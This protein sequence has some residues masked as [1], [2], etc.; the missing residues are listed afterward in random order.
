MILLVHASP[1]TLEPYRTPHL[2]V[3]CSPRRVY[4]DEL[5]GWTWAADNDAFSAW[6]EL[7]YYEMLERIEG[8]SGC[9]FVTAPDR[10]GDAY[11][12]LQLFNEWFPRL[13]GR[14]PIGYV[15]QDGQENEPVP[16]EAI[17]AVFVGGTDTFKMGP[18]AAQLVREAKDR[19]LWVHMGRVNGH[20]RLRYAKALGC[21]SVD[22]T[23]LSWFRDRWLPEYLAHAA[24]PAQGMLA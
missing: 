13:E 16:W 17:D 21:D 14:F 24:Q 8:R 15:L 20:R 10:V 23:S 6:N 12:T 11:G 2:G 1:T 19:G 5:A 22:G 9:V 7:R 3:L 18:V 4:G